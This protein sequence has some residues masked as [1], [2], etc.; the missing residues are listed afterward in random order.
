M[1]AVLKKIGIL[2]FVCLI[3]L[4]ARGQELKCNIQVSSGKIQGTTGQ[5]FQTLQTALYEF[6]NTRAW[7]KHYYTEEE[8]SNVTFYCS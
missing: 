7:T 2:S 5:V 8:K 4:S 3:G 6:M 1:N